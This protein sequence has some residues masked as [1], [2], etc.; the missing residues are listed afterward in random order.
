MVNET[1]DA[2]CV[3]SQRNCVSF[4]PMQSTS[5]VKMLAHV[6]VYETVSDSELE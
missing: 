4:T 1:P 6:S 3:A 2:K 5:M